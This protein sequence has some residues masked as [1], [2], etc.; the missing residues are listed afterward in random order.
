MYDYDRVC[1][2][3]IDEWIWVL[4]IILS[5]LNIFGDECEKNY[6]ISHSGRGKDISKRVFSFTI[7]SSLFIYLYLEYQRYNHLVDCI[8]KQQ[9][10]SLW[11][12]RCFGGLLVIIATI[13]FLYC[14]L[15]E[16]DPVN[17]GIE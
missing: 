5:S 10:T 15:V 13:L 17:P 9:N 3:K 1:E 11:K 6:C 4:F 16:S 2:L 14:Q 12:V 8:N 7:F